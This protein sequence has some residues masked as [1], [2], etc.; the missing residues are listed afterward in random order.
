[1]V[2][3]WRRRAKPDADS[4]PPEYVNV[5]GQPP[6]TSYKMDDVEGTPPPEY[7]PRPAADNHQRARVKPRFQPDPQVAGSGTEVPASPANRSLDQSG[8]AD[9]GVDAVGGPLPHGCTTAPEAAP[10]DASVNRS[11]RRQPR[12][13]SQSTDAAPLGYVNRSFVDDTGVSDRPISAQRGDAPRP[14]RKPRRSV[15]DTIPVD[16]SVP[17]DNA[18]ADRSFEIVAPVLDAELPVP[19][20]GFK[21][22]ADGGLNDRPSGRRAHTGVDNSAFDRLFPPP[23]RSNPAPLPSGLGARSYENLQVAPPGDNKPDRRLNRSY[24]PSAYLPD[25]ASF[26]AGSRQGSAPDVRGSA[27][28][29]FN[30]DTQSIDV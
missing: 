14:A 12:R 28:I 2:A 10:A 22:D 11:L 13:V 16:A 5:V 29:R 30:T 21:D 18:P 17:L 7:C 9:L 8:F 20:R 23:G 27:T 4:S 3:G 24:D 26:A 15:D 25:S 1:V 19:S 6:T